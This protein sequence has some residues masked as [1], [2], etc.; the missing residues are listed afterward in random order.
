M[1]SNLLSVDYKIASEQLFFSK[2]DRKMIQFWA[3]LTEIHQDWGGAGQLM[4]IIG[5]IFCCSLRELLWCFLLG[6][7]IMLKDIRAL[8][9]KVFVFY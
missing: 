3:K 1:Q 4:Y 6:Y 9:T 2:V 7:I 8:L 5:D